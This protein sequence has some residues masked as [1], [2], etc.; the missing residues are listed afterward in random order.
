MLYSRTKNSISKYDQNEVAPQKRVTPCA[1]IVDGD[2]AARALST[3][4]LEERGCR[5][6]SAGSGEEAL[7]LLNEKQP[8]DLVVTDVTLP[9]MSGLDLVRTIRQTAG[10][11][12][13]P[14]I[15]CSSF[16][17]ETT[18]KKAVEY[19]CNRFLLTPVHPEFLF[20]QVR[21]LLHDRVTFSR[22]IQL[23]QA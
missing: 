21:T 10:S 20:E 3:V 6:L 17:D 12:H 8:V 4:G 18:V 14:V 15:L 16:I 9:K 2:G 1:L 7:R 5:T 19:K 23:K 11:G 13:L 22:N